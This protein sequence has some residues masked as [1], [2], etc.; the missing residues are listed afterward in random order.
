M[1]LQQLSCN[2]SSCY[3]LLLLAM[4]VFPCLLSTASQLLLLPLRLLLLLR[5]CTAQHLLHTWP[6]CSRLNTLCWLLPLQ[7]AW[8][9]LLLLCI[10]NLV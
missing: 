2:S 9:L 7:L 4:L 3:L 1:L 5:V 10:D 8:L 6:V